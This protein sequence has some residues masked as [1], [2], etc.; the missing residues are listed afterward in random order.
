MYNEWDDW[1]IV[2][3]KLGRVA[4][5][6]FGLSEG[7]YCL[8]ELPEKCRRRGVP[9]KVEREA[10]VYERLSG[11]KIDI[12]GWGFMQ[13]EIPTGFWSYKNYKYSY[14]FLRELKERLG[15]LELEEQQAVDFLEAQAQL[16][17]ELLS[18]RGSVETR[19]A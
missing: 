19:A 8:S 18:Q 1:E 6:L 17:R 9:E 13:H 2:T 14:R 5:P 15:S 11:E 4:R 7:Y 12:A 3:Q 10:T 16:L